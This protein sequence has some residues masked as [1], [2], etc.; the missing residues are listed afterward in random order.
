MEETEVKEIKEVQEEKKEEVVTET[1]K[2]YLL[3]E[4]PT[5]SALAFQRPD[6]TVLTQEQLLV[7][8]VNK[9]DK[10]ESAVA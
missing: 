1:K 4:V 10:I 2:E 6:G 9:L 5:G 3:V 7:E 8:I